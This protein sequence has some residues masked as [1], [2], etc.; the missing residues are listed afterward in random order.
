MGHKYRT[1]ASQVV[2]QVQVWLQ[3]SSIAKLKNVQVIA[4]HIPGTDTAAELGTI[5]TSGFACQFSSKACLYV[6][7]LQCC[8]IGVTICFI[9]HCQF[10]V[11]EKVVSHGLLITEHSI[12]SGQSANTSSNV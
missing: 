7:K 1:H 2:L 5:T 3:H 12:G 11:P 10:E 8:P 9:H 6:L 4:G